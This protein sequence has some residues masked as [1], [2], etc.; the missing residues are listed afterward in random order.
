M[1]NT[2]MQLG[3]TTMQ[4]GDTTMQTGG[5]TMQTQAPNQANTGPA[6]LGGRRANPY[7]G[8]QPAPAAP[9]NPTAPAT[10]NPFQERAKNMVAQIKNSSD[11]SAVLQNSFQAIDMFDSGFAN[12][13]NKLDPSVQQNVLMSYANNIR[14]GRQT[15][16][17]DEAR[18][19]ATAAA[20]DIFDPYP[21]IVAKEKAAAA[22]KAKAAAAAKKAADDKEERMQA[23]RRR[24]SRANQRRMRQRRK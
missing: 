3:G 9:V 13:L 12:K 20:P 6:L 18:A 22:A 24:S 23:S 4:T 1:I 14:Q 19:M 17:L 7:A 11:Q 5:T 2:A 16:A 10:Q 15:D 8:T 21:G